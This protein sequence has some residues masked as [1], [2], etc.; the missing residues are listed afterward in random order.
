MFSPYTRALKRLQCHSHAR[1]T[2]VRLARMTHISRARR[3]LRLRAMFAA[4]PVLFAHALVHCILEKLYWLH[5]T[6][7]Q[8]AGSVDVPLDLE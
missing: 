2:P 1:V 8:V 7:T 5:F 4:A 6:D 3:S